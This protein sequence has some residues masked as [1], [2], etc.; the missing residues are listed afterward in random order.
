MVVEVHDIDADKNNVTYFSNYL[1]Q[2]GFSVTHQPINNFCH[3]LE[4]EKIG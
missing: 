4:A 3:A 1:V 2:L